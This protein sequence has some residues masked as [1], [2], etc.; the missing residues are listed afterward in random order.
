MNLSFR[1]SLFASAIALSVVPLVVSTTPSIAQEEVVSFRAFHRALA[2][3]G[4]WVYSDR[5]GEVWIPVNVPEDFHPYGTGGHWGDT[6]QYG[7]TS[8]PFSR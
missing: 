5:W 1:A 3:H 2:A 4:D 7:W 6:D 8:T